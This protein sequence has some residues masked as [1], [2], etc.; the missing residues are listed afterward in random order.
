[1][2]GGIRIVGRVADPVRALGR[3]AGK[4]VETAATSAVKVFGNIVTGAN[5]TVG[6]AAK[7]VNGTVGAIFKSRRN[8]N[9]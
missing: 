4:T 5:R 8:R 3:G 9:H 6:A 7:A 1:M 2:M